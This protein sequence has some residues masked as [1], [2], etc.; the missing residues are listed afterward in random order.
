MAGGDYG[1]GEEE[2]VHELSQSEARELVEAV[3]PQQLNTHEGRNQPHLSQTRAAII[4]RP[5]DGLGAES[6]GFD[7]MPGLKTIR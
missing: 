4:S 7:Q 2:S 3:G 5:S 6:Q 1:E